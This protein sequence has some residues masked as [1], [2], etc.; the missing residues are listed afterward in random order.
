MENSDFATD[1]ILEI[2]V[3]LVWR[4]DH[5]K[6]REMSG[7]WGLVHLQSGNPGTI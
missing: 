5:C 1:L 3:F 7:G 2:L 4:E 6:R